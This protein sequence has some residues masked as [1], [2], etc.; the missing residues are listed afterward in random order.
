MSIY[1]TC[2]KCGVG[3]DDGECPNCHF[4]DLN[5]YAHATGK[6]LSGYRKEVVD[7]RVNVR[8]V[9]MEMSKEKI[10]TKSRIDGVARSIEEALGL[11]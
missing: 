9:L 6:L 3:L 11:E 1:T 2:A 5:D 8:E 4:T 10:L 7:M